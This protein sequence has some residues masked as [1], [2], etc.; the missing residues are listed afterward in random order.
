MKKSG[1]NSSTQASA[2]SSTSHNRHLTRNQF[3]VTAAKTSIASVDATMTLTSSED[4]VD[5][6]QQQLRVEDPDERQD[7]GAQRVQRTL[8][9]RWRSRL[10]PEIAAAANVARP[11]GGVMS[12]MI[13]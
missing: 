12:P 1:R 6:D 7:H 13:P 9:P 11:T 3:I 4:A 10:S 2:S 5:V 8:D